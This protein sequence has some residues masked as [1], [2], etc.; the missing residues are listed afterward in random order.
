MPFPSNLADAAAAVADGTI[1]VID[2]VTIGSVIVGALRSV[3]APE[4]LRVTRKAVQV[5]YDINDAAVTE[6]KELYL[7][8]CL[9][10]PDFSAEGMLGAVAT[11]NPGDYLTT[12]RDKRDMLYQMKNDKELVTVQTHARLHKK[13]LVDEID[14]AYDADE[15]FE[16]FFATVHLTEIRQKLTILEG[17]VD[18]A[19]Q[20]VGGL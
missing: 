10:N 17:L 7:E 2:T 14:P 8:V 12:W 6:S 1:G 18:Q 19:E 3:Q 16:C 5:G 4:R 11:G 9:T 15:N 13:M 20:G